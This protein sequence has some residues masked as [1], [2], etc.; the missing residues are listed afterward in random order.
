MVKYKGR[1]FFRQ[2]M[3]KKPIKWG[4][5]VWMIAEPKTGYVSNFTVYLGK[6]SS[7][8]NAGQALG[9]RGLRHQQVL[10]PYPSPLVL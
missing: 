3:P 10:S 9:T 8:E 1:V 2:Y 6:C 5:K 7:S 4:I